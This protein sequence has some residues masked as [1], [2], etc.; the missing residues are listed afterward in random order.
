MLAGDERA[1]AEASAYLDAKT[2]TGIS[3]SEDR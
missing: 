2:T 3:G 1:K